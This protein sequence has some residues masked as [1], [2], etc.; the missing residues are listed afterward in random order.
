MGRDRPDEAVTLLEEAVSEDRTLAGA[1]NAL[2]VAWL[3]Q[4]ERT[5]ARL[6]LD[7]AIESDPGS[8]QAWYNRGLLRCQIGDLDGGIVDFQRSIQL[9]PSNMRTVRVI[10]LAKLAKREGKTFLPGTDSLGAWSP[11]PVDVAKHDEGEFSP[12]APNAGE[13]WLRHIE[14]VLS[15]SM[16]EAGRNARAE[17]FDAA[18]LA[19]IEQDY[20]TDPSP[21]KRKI[22]AFGF[23]WLD[24]PD[25]AQRVLAP[26][27]GRD[28]DADEMLL[29]LWL[30][31][32]AGESQRLAM[33]AREMSASARLEMAGFRW[34]ILALDLLGER[35]PMA[36][37]WGN[38]LPTGMGLPTAKVTWQKHVNFQ[39][40]RMN[41]MIGDRNGPMLRSFGG[42]NYGTF[43]HGTVVRG[44]HYGKVGLGSGAAK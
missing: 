24:L 36:F 27:W 11:A 31:Q 33:L 41:N 2:G 39:S 12:Q 40:L 42:N 1:W 20:R 34:S 43:Y 19:N 29:L 13:V 9:D 4:G 37:A 23:T 8:V 5:N 21:E 26:H 7:R 35:N 3:Q 38:L 16:E 28:L 6:A 17:G 32:R 44:H 10:Q 14:K 18:E 30:D 22:L 15:E 25:E